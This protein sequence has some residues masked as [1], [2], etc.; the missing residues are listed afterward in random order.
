MASYAYAR[1]PDRE[2]GHTWQF[3]HTLKNFRSGLCPPSLLCTPNILTAA[4][5]EARLDRIILARCL[6]LLFFPPL[7]SALLPALAALLS[8][9]RMLSVRSSDGGAAVAVKVVPSL[10]VAMVGR[11]LKGWY[12]ARHVRAACSSMGISQSICLDTKR[13]ILQDGKPPPSSPTP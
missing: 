12:S 6:F 8:A 9:L 7:M 10:A 13:N 3:P 5:S 1:K 2:E 4:A 11:Y